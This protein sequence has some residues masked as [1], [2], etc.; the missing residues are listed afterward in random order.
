VVAS[1]EWMRHVGQNTIRGHKGF[2]QSACGF[3]SPD[4]PFFQDKLA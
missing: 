3:F 1:F 4:H 2:T